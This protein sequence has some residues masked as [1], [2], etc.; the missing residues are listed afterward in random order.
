MAFG[1]FGLVV[2][3]QIIQ[4]YRV[5]YFGRLKGVSKSVQVLFNGIEA[6]YGT[7]IENSEI[8]SRVEKNR[9]RQNRLQWNG[10][11]V[12][13]KLLRSRTDTVSSGLKL[14]F[15]TYFRSCGIDFDILHKCGKSACTSECW[16][17]LW[18]HWNPTCVFGLPVCLQGECK[19]PSC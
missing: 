15:W 9:I 2:T 1:S 14:K 18:A 16:R 13:W 7:D 3:G 6:I 5:C 4:Q 17:G 10:L 8:A 11:A 19:L 12:L